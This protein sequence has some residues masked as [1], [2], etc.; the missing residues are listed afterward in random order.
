[1]EPIAG[2]VEREIGEME[3][4][5]R[6]DPQCQALNYI[7]EMMPQDPLRSNCTSKGGS[8][9]KFYLSFMEPAL[10]ADT[11]LTANSK[12][13]LRLGG[14]FVRSN[15]CWLAVALRDLVH[16]PDPGNSDATGE[17]GTHHSPDP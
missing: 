3:F 14:S 2:L 7:A 9:Q 1:L 11:H 13:R 5:S 6:K 17:G 15:G 12:P 4:L 16:I 8:R 10:H